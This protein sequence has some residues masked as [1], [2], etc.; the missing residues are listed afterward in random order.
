MTSASLRPPK[1]PPKRTSRPLSLAALRREFHTAFKA[2]KGGAWKPRSASPGPPYWVFLATRLAS[3]RRGGK[4]P[5]GGAMDGFIDNVLWAQYCLFMF[6]R[7]Q[8]DLF[9]GHVRSPSII[10]LSDQFLWEAEEVLGR[11]FPRSPAFWTMF[12]RCMRDTTRAIL[13]VDALQRTCSRSGRTLL[14]LYARVDSV[15]MISLFAVCIRY[16][17]R[18]AFG[19]IKKF[20]HEVAEGS[21][22]LDDLADVSEDLERGRFNYAARVLLGNCRKRGPAGASLVRRALHNL[23]FTPR[24]SGLLDEASRHFAAAGKAL[25]ALRIRD[26]GQFTQGY[27]LLLEQ[28]R[29][30]LHRKTVK[31]LFAA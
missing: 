31:Y 7:L 23:H 26:G 16:R 3:P 11:Y 22:I 17:R 20:V 27:M 25:R 24:G 14:P 28:I 6:I 4:R 21:Q 15:F 29:K 2:G 10:L 13:Q 19:L 8:D 1:R 18:A 5:H 30:Q 9:D 12:R